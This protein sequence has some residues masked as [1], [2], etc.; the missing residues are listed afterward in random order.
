MIT[1]AQCRAARGLL[2]WTQQDLAD[3]SGLS[4]T[5]INNFEKSH[6]DIKAESLRAIRM[7][8]ES[9]DIEFMTDGLHKRNETSRVLKGPAAFDELFNDIFETLKV[10]G[11]E[12][13][14]TCTDDSVNSRISPAKISEHLIRMKNSNIALRAIC[15]ENALPQLSRL[16]AQC[17]CLGGDKANA[18]IMMMIYGHKVALELWNNAMIVILSSSDAAKAEALRFEHLWSRAKNPDASIKGGSTTNA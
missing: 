1:V 4:K 13:L 12:I 6:S 9:A 3:A 14:M 18:G 17:R 15:Y 11:G 2:D 5:A 16:N 7:A 8:F 10:S